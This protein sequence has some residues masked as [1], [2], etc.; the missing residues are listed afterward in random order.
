MTSL[1][2]LF[3]SFQSFHSIN[4]DEFCVA[5]IVL[6]IKAWG[7]IHAFMPDKGGS[8]SPPPNG[9]QFFHFYIHFYHTVPASEIGARLYPPSSLTG[10][11]GSAPD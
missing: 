8:A 4:H 7:Y 9:T 5:L 10:K 3:V 6:G 1:G 11:S 2:F